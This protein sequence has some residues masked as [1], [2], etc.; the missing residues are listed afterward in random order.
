M[1]AT[2][3]TRFILLPCVSRRRSSKRVMVTPPTP[4]PLPPVACTKAYTGDLEH[5]ACMPWCISVRHQH[6]RTYNCWRC[7]CRACN[8]CMAV[9]VSRQ[10]SAPDPREHH[11]PTE[12]NHQYCTAAFRDRNHR[13]HRL[14]GA[15]GWVVHEH[16]E[17]SSSC[18]GN[19]SEPFF[20][21]AW[22]GTRCGRNWYT[23]SPG[24]LGKPRRGGPVNPK[25]E[26]HFQHPT[27]PALL[28]FDE[29]VG[30]RTP[31]SPLSHFQ[32]ALHQACARACGPHPLLSTCLSSCYSICCIAHR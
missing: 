17:S 27:A 18:F 22:F 23:G 11:T 1:H 13:F 3:G 20:D 14:W 30:A 21:D 28:G 6:N 25:N 2:L 10:S 5:E 9:A 8:E 29:S 32:A 15:T 19:N 12:F 16:N 26:I 24:G 4:I 7:K 31:R